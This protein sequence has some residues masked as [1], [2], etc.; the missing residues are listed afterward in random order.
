MNEIS[1]KNRQ[2]CETNMFTSF[3]KEGQVGLSLV[4]WRIYP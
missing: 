3:Y 2:K 1:E 4:D